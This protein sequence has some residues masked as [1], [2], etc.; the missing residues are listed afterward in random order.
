MR[1]FADMISALKIPLLC[2]VAMAAYR[3]VFPPDTMTNGEVYFRNTLLVMLAFSIIIAASKKLR[4][5]IWSKFTRE[6]KETSDS[7]TVHAPLGFGINRGSKSTV[8]MPPERKPFDAILGV[9]PLSLAGFR[10]PK[11]RIGVKIENGNRRLVIYD[12]WLRDDDGAESRNL[13]MRN[14]GLQGNP[15]ELNPN[16]DHVLHFSPINEWTPG[17][18]VTICVQTD[19]QTGRIYEFATELPPLPRP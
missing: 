4:L 6:P 16:E 7:E 14:H 1:K 2:V 10:A 13:V 5:W 18:P 11:D 9:Y 12:L 8:V 19:G 3:W 17:E 15:L